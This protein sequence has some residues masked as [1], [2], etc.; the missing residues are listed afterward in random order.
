MIT[1]EE[2]E[3]ARREAQL[4]RA[5][6]RLGYKLVKS[7]YAMT[8]GTFGIIDPDYNAW[9]YYTGYNGYGMD[10]DDVE[11]WL[12]NGDEDRSTAAVDVSASRGARG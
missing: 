2:F 8:Q 6:R 5:V 7:R 1:A 9:F 11:A 10:L 4:R 3:E 12:S